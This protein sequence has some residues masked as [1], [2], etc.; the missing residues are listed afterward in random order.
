[1]LN[2][3][4]NLEVNAGAPLDAR[5]VV[6]TADDLIVASNFPYPYVG[7]PVVVQDV[8]DM[9][10]LMDRDVTNIANWKKIGSGG[11][12]GGGSTYYSMSNTKQITESTNNQ[13][14]HF[15]YYNS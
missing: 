10:I 11:G 3:S 14:Y 8:G 5:T 7:M 13:E 6:P 12:G 2:L 1:M 15:D 4:G 9:Y